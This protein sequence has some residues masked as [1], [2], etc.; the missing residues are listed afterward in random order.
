TQ[1]HRP[2][3]YREPFCPASH[4]PRNSRKNTGDG[5]VIRLRLSYDGTD[6]IEGIAYRSRI[7]EDTENSVIAALVIMFEPDQLATLL[8]GLLAGDVIGRRLDPQ[9]I[10]TGLKVLPFKHG[11]ELGFQR[12]HLKAEADGLIDQSHRHTPL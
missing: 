7:G 9:R 11:G 4:P 6:S 8:G 5:R 2:R 10:V 3:R 12:L 1:D